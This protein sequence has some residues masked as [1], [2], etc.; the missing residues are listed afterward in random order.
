MLFLSQILN[1]NRHLTDLTDLI[2]L[3]GN[4]RQRGMVLTGMQLEGHSSLDLVLGGM[5]HMVAG[6][7]LLDRVDIVIEVDLVTVGLANLENFYFLFVFL[8]PLVV[9]DEVLGDKPCFEEPHF[10]LDFQ[11]QVGIRRPRVL[12]QLSPS[13]L[14]VFKYYY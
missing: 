11:L 14:H 7:L 9:D 10:G 1:P 3:I 12:A 5:R 8:Q 13:D 4:V 6:Y 2:V